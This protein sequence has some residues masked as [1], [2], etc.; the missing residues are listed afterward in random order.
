[1]RDCS[2]A[3]HLRHALAS[4]TVAVRDR[5]GR[6]IGKLRKEEAADSRKRALPISL[7]IVNKVESTL[8]P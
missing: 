4:T 7:S 3:A 6:P 1:M 2:P 5:R 8:S